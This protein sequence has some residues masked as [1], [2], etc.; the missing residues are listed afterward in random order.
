MRVISP[1]KLRLFWERQKTAER[2]L[3]M[4]L[5]VVES[6]EWK[7][8]VDVR[9]TFR[10]A[11]LVRVKSGGSVVVFDIGGNK[12]RVI[13]A[14]HYDAQRVFVLRVFTHAEYDRT[15]WKDEL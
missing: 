1:K 11:D 2:P 12:F 6:A 5:K 9:D 14:V 7:T 3:R 13:S 15:N 8:F 4:W 10:S